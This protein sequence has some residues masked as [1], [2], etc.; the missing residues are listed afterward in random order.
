MNYSKYIFILF[1]LLLSCKINNKQKEGVLNTKVVSNNFTIAFGSCNNQVLPN[2]MWKEILKSKPN[3]W[4]WGGDVIY[5]DTKDMSLMSQN[6]QKQKNKSE[7]ANFIKN[8]DVIGTWDDHDYGLNDGGIEYSKKEEAQ[9]L[10]LDFIN[11]DKNDER[12]QQEGVY[13]AKD[14]SINDNSVKIIILDTRYFRTALT[15]DTITQK[16]Y[17]PNVYGEGSMLG[18]IQWKWLKE[19]LQNS[20]ASF[21]I[22]V[23][24]IQFL[25]SEHGFESW[26]NMPHEVDKLIN[27]VKTTNAKNTIILS[28]D[29]HISEF[30]KIEVDNLAYPI[31]D[32]TSSGLT[33]SYTNFNGEPNQY[34]TGKVVFE[35][36]F[37]ILKFDFDK[38][39]VTMQMRGENN[40]LQQ[41]LIHQY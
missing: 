41:E 9:D 7:Y 15:K 36:S 29:R 11:V 3:V 5:T 20:K 16:R 23:S 32:F 14:Y 2:V 40:V 37:G 28:G 8:V 26:G 21:N 31:I 10:F 35:K 38:L 17:K 39:R 4:I 30:S 24:S 27:Q 34:R 1:I 12:R 13:F 33:H 6:Y 19:Q 18:E 25:S 22:I